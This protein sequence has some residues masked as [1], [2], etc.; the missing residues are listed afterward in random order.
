MPDDYA[1]VIG[2]NN[3]AV[4]GTDGFPALSSS[5]RDA[6]LFIEWL[7]SP[8]GGNIQDDPTGKPRIYTMFS[9]ERLDGS[10]PDLD[11]A[12]PIKEEIDNALRKM[13]ASGTDK[14][15]RR[16]YF[17]FSGHGVGP[18]AKDVAMLMANA[19][20]TMESRNI[21]FGHYREFIRERALFDQVVFIADCC[22][23]RDTRPR[24]DLGKPPFL[25][26]PAEDIS[27]VQDIAIMAA[28]YGEPA[29]AIKQGHGLLTTALIEGLKGD[30]E[31]VDQKGRIT[32]GSL[33]RYLPGKVKALGREDLLSQEAVVNSEPE[34]KEMVIAVVDRKV[35]IKVTAAPAVA[36]EIIILDGKD[37]EIIRRDA[38]LAR[39]ADPWHVE[40]TDSAVPYRVRVP[41]SNNVTELKLSDVKKAN[42]E[43]FI[44]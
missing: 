21:G 36:G 4:D 17:Y 19:I 3:Y 5:L 28:E 39:A 15:G 40:L 14:I 8:T 18:S 10:L 37:E 33:K 30:P 13:G 24:L 38:D 41:G 31:A 43:F 2:I 22:R 25:T 29:Y 11:D 26:D 35:T 23:T 1:I 6:S 44:P 20:R 12:K 32:T 7:Q 42:N 34:H 9:H 27:G 16:L